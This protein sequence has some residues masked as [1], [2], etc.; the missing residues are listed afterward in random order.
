[1]GALPTA[2]TSCLCLTC[3]E[4]KEW[5]DYGT[6]RVPLTVRNG[7]EI[8]KVNFAEPGEIDATRR[9]TNSA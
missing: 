1:M 4:G 5:R 7:T 3:S 2:L 8:A 6:S 9:Q